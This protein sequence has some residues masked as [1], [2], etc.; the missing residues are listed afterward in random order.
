LV[1]LEPC[2]LCSAA[3]AISHV[4]KVLFAGRDP[5]WSY[6][7]TLPSADPRL[8]ERWP[9]IQGPIVG[10]LGV[11]ASLVPLIERLERNPVGARVEEFERE[12]PAVA[13]LA[14]TLVTDGT[15]SR[16]RQLGL[17]GALDDVWN[18]LDI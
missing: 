12:L 5:V 18:R 7:R 13:S 15:A 4:P 1:T 9:H 3:V 17:D 2:L 11:W 14:R 10:P 6:L 16:L 8:T